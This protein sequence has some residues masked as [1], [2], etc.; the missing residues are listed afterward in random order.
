M[1]ADVAMTFDVRAIDVAVL[2]CD[3]TG[4]EVVNR[5]AGMPEVGRLML[6]TAPYTR[7][8]RPPLKK[9]RRLLKYEGPPGLARAIGRRLKAVAG[10]SERTRSNTIGSIASIVPSRV[11]HVHVADLHGDTCVAALREFA[12][13]LGV[14]VGTYI[15][16]PSIFEIPTLGMINLHSG[17]A[18]QYRGSAPVFWE[19]YNGET[20]VG[21]T[22]HWV[23]SA[24]DAGHIIRQQ[25]FPLDSAPEGDPLNYIERYRREV[26]GPNGIRLLLDAVGHVAAAGRVGTPQDSAH[27]ATYPLPDY[28]TVRELRKRVKE[29]QRQVR[30]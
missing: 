15:L 11:R 16:Q 6:A 7:R 21:I 5:L 18:P 14:V 28:R 17:K 29:R 10:Q 4:I 20:E 9:L 27:A 1:N 30:A 12:P 19:L 22:I 3:S 2:S 24:L 13:T 25:T 8:R 26:L 23:E